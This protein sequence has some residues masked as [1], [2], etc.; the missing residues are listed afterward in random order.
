M[1]NYELPTASSLVLGGIKVGT[2][3]DITPEGVLNA[4]D[5]TYDIVSDEAPG[6]MSSED[7]AKLDNLGNQESTLEGK[8]GEIETSLNNKVDKEEGKILTSNDFTNDLKDKLDSLEN[9]ELPIAS[10][11]ELGG[12]KVG[13][14]LSIDT[15]GKLNAKDTTYENATEEEA[16]LMAAGDKAKLN[17]LK[18]YDDTDLQTRVGDLET[19]IENKV[20]N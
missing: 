10:A 11:L 13:D 18:N 7:K 3:L 8:V 2:N 20:D 12:I 9:Y 19:G 4:T 16:G 5:T 15:T 1:K 17:K 6:L 14:N